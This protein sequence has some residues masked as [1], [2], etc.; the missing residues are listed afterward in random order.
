MQAH[1]ATHQ[2]DQ[3][4]ADGEAQSG[5]A[6]AL[7][8][9]TICLGKGFEHRSLLF[10]RNADAAVTYQKTHVFTRGSIFSMGFAFDFQADLTL[11]GEF[12]GI[13]EQVE[14][15]LPDSHRVGHDPVRQVGVELDGESDV[16]F[17]ATWF[18]QP[19]QFGHQFTWAHGF[20]V[21]IE[22]P[23]FDLGKIENVVEDGQQG[24]GRRVG[25]VQI[26]VL[27]FV[28]RCIQRQPQHAQHAIHGRAD[29]MAHVGKKLAFRLACGLCILFRLTQLDFM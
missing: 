14:Q 24:V 21:H 11:R 10:F 19:A 5:T 4:V 25:K 13:A 26:L 2:L 3:M 29:F 16:L 17:T 8:D 12:Q 6:K 27:L 22:S 20:N 9:G 15:H 18:I 23:G 28:Q 7:G 1:A